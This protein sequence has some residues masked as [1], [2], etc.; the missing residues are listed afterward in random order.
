M[1]LISL[2]ATGDGG[3]ANMGD[4]IATHSSVEDFLNFFRSRKF[5]INS[6]DLYNFEI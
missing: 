2:A 5:I 1:Y 3:V 6:V 4:A